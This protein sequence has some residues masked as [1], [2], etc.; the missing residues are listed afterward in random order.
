MLSHTGDGIYCDYCGAP[1]TG[2]FSYYSFDF[3]ENKVVDRFRNEYDQTLTADLCQS[4]MNLFR[5]RLNQVS[6]IVVESERRCDVT[7]EDMGLDDHEYYKCYVSEVH[8]NLSDQPYKCLKC[9]ETRDPDEGPCDECEEGTKLYREAKVDADEHFVVLNF[10]K[11]IYK[12]FIDHL[13]SV[14]KIGENEW[15]NQ[16]T[17]QT[18]QS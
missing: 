16:T 18:N 1:Y 4:C 9:H 12:K 10:S 15:I 14:R 17:N 13:D 7:G 2:D 5:D 8:V 3:K 11:R 6:E